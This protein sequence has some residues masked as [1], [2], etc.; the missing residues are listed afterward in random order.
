[1]S[2]PFPFV[3]LSLSFPFIKRLYSSRVP[4]SSLSTVLMVCFRLHW[5]IL[6]FE[7]LTIAGFVNLRWL[8]FP[9]RW[10]LAFTIFYSNFS[11]ISIP[12]WLVKLWGGG[13]VFLYLLR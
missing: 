9:L 5:Y 4:V 8:V 12:V 7:F 13:L 10:L 11:L 6:D 3:Q 1:M 2:F